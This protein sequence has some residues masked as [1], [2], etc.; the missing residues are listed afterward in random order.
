MSQIPET[1]RR[2]VECNWIEG[3]VKTCQ[4]ATEYCYWTPAEVHIA[5]FKAPGEYREFKSMFKVIEE[6][7]TINMSIGEL[8][9]WLRE[10]GNEY[11]C[12]GGGLGI[13]TAG[14]SRGE[15]FRLLS[16][17]AGRGLWSGF[18][19]VVIVGDVAYYL[20]ARFG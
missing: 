5:Q 8:L 17:R 14:I 1:L 7:D 2:L 15:Y 3:G 12:I 20:R 16:V 18:N 19:G 9:D 6:E 10:H 11:L 13:C 4:C